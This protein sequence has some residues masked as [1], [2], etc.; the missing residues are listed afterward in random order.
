MVGGLEKD[1]RRED[2]KGTRREEICEGK[3]ED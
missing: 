3:L 2:E 1:R